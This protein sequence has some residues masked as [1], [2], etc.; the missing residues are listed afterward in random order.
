MRID[1][2]PAFILHTRDYRDSSLL[3]EFITVDYGRVSAV[4]KGVK[5]TGKVA[6]LRRSQ[7]QPFIPLLICWTGKTGLK[8]ITRFETRGAP[9]GLTGPRLFSA[10]Y[11]NEL[12]NRLVEHYD[13]QPELYS[14][15]EWVV[16][17]LLKEPLVD[18]VLRKFELS[19]LESLGYGLNFICDVESGKAIDQSRNYRFIAD[20]GFTESLVAGESA[21]YFSGDD[22]L[23]IYQ[24]HYSESVRRVAKR[25]CRLALAQ[26]L[27]HKP[28]KSRELFSSPH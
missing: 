16:N 15:Y 23:A 4:V 7:L 1:A 11:V 6:K 10:I 18:V 9:L 27:G 19:L 2:Q 3:V 17:A 25:L 24:G 5:A 12:L 22:L 14:L 8:T 21:H 20:Q 13:Q 28:L 26:H